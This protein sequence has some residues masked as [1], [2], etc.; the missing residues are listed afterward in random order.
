MSSLHAHPYRQLFTLTSART[1][2]ASSWD[3]TGGNHD[4]IQI[5]AGET[6]TLLEVEGPGC[7]THFYWTMINADPFDLRDAVQA[8]FGGKLHESN[9]CTGGHGLTKSVRGV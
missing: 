3:R 5:G 9:V 8:R 2:R 1:K 7:I 4:F 6:A